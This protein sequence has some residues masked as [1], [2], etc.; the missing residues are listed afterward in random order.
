MSK[1]LGLIKQECLRP[2]IDILPLHEFNSSMYYVLP[3][4]YIILTEYL[5]Q[6]FF[7]FMLETCFFCC[8][9]VI[10][11]VYSQI[12]HRYDKFNSNL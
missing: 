11:K 7:C 4:T 1:R 5:W 10:N 6:I 2:D 12:L 8:E 9:I 3:L